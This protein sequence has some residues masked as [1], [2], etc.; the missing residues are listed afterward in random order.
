MTESLKSL[1]VQQAASV[2]FKPPD[3]NAIARDNSRRLRRR[4]AAIMLA[5][6][7]VLAIVASTAVI[8][9]NSAGRRPVGASP[10][11]IAV[12]WAVGS[13]IHNG[14]DSFEVGHDVR[15]YVRTSVG[16]VTLDGADNVYSVTDRGVTRIGQAVPASSSAQQP[17][18]VSDPHGSLAGW[19]GTDQGALVLQVHDQATGKTRTYSTEGAGPPGGAVFFAI[20][21]RTAYWR[22]APRTGVFAVDVD[23]GEEAQLS[24]GDEALTLEIW[25]VE[26]GVLAFSPDHR[27]RSNVTSIRVGRSIRDTREIT[28]GENMEANELILL[29]PTGAWLTYLL[30]EF[31]GPPQNDDL[32]AMPMQVRDTSTGALVT[33]NLP[34]TGLA[35]PVSW[36][37]DTTLQVLAVGQVPGQATQQANMYTC[38]FPTGTCVV[39]ADLPL[40]AL[41]DNDLV[42]PNGRSF[43]D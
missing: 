12:S 24:S 35:I 4:R 40:A 17:R 5:G 34:P 41:M 19:V 33:L 26:N 15:A 38:G 22:V 30:Y 21:D 13:T 37:D 1:L 28:F 23:T 6:A 20:D 8:L 43:E 27:P 10:L 29:S 36:L 18:L 11:P 16:F 39:A 9:S 42:V 7:A 25:S 31:N 3:L 14:A 2:A 32:L